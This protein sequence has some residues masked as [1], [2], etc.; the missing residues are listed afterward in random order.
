MH[1]IQ[2][3]FKLD[4]HAE[5]RERIGLYSRMASWRDVLALF[6]STDVVGKPVDIDEGWSVLVVRII[7]PGVPG[8]IIV[9]GSGL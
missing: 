6:G 4:W 3:A 2:H 7:L 5:A 9:P 8:S 1:W